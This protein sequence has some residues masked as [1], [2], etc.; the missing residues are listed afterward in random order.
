MTADLYLP[1]YDLE[2]GART[3][4]V[5]AWIVDVAPHLAHVETFAVHSDPKFLD[6]WQ[7]SDIETGMRIVYGIWFSRDACIAWARSRLSTKTV[8]DLL[9]AYKSLEGRVNCL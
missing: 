9:R 1:L 7:I 5:P 4:I 8:A 6:G 3:T 2:T